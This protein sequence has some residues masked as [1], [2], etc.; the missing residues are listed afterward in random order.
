M[1]CHHNTSGLRTIKYTRSQ[2]SV[3]QDELPLCLAQNA[4]SCL[5]IGRLRCW[6]CRGQSLCTVEALR[7][8]E[9]QR[10]HLGLKSNCRKL[11]IQADP[12]PVSPGSMPLPGANQGIGPTQFR[13]CTGS[14]ETSDATT[15]RH[16]K[17][18]ALGVCLHFSA[19]NAMTGYDHIKP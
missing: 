12:R 15:L 18:E 19:A 5:G 1:G 17:L 16:A 14:R 11:L 7:L 13:S 10:N 4:L 3:V 8:P 9:N 2:S 6:P